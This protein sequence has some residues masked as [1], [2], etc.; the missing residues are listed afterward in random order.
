M[1]GSWTAG[2][3]AICL[4]LAGCNG[5]GPDS[6]PVTT[7][8]KPI[9]RR[10]VAELPPVGAYAPPLDGNLLEVAP[11][12][13]WNLIRG[14]TF[15]I[16]WAKGT[17]S[18]LT[19]ITINAEQPPTGSPEQLTEENAAEFAARLDQELKKSTKQ[20]EETCLP[21]ILGQTVF[22][23]H[24]RRVELQSSPCIL[25]SLQTI[26]NSRLYTVEL[27]AEI[28]APQAS[29]YE[30]SLLAVRDFGYAVAANM[31]F[32]PPGEKFDPL[33]GLPK[34]EPAQPKAKPKIDNKTPA[35][36]KSGQ[37]KPPA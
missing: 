16:G 18:D 27:V 33:A 15:L 6:G 5:P 2:L 8:P 35:E 1:N 25:Q 21:I 9:L 7:E 32:A 22:I 19:R 29:N 26:Q 36:K 20:V 10:Q 4:A 3:L 24:V 30:E 28:D 31:R 14:R 23:R 11:P 17:P 37:P 12:E 34:P 13:G